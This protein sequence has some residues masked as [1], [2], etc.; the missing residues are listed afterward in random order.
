NILQ[1]REDPYSFILN[2]YFV[3]R[4]IGNNPQRIIRFVNE[5]A[6]T[7]RKF[8]PNIYDFLITKMSFLIG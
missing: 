1:N 2:H 5:M 6:E 3:K 7:F 8:K 4:E